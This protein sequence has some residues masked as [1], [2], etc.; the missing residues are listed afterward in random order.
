MHHQERTVVVLGAEL[1]HQSVDA[2]GRIERE[3]HCDHP[4]ERDATHGDA[5]ETEVVQELEE[6][7]CERLDRA[8]PLEEW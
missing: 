2:V 4:A 8:R 6:A 3:C 5:F 7:E 1:V